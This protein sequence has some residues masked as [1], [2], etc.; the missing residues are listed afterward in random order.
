M[1]GVDARPAPGDLEAALVLHRGSFTLDVALTARAGHPLALI[2]PNG[3]GKSTALLAIAG[4]LALD[5]G[6]VHVGGRV[7]ADAVAGV[8][9]P[10][11]ERAVG[12]VFQGYALFPHLTVRENIA[13]GPRA[14]GRGR[15]SARLKAEQWMA[16]IGLTA[17]ADMLPG[18]LSGGQ[19]QRVALARALAARPQALLLDEPLSA[20]DVEVRDSVRAD[21]A[22]HVRAFGGVTVVVAHDREDVAALAEQVLVIEGGRVVQRGTLAELTADPAS[23]FVRRFTAGTSPSFPPSGSA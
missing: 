2:G 13:F 16:R 3:A 22:A 1:N 6:H 20:L 7:L 21:L 17:L 14:Q 10:A 18:Q 5:A 4:A 11:A 23:E 15:A 12:V 9:R 19:A 8:D